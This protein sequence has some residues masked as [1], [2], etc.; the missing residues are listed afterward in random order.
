MQSTT[1]HSTTFVAPRFE[2][3]KTLFLQVKRFPQAI[4]EALLMDRSVLQVQQILAGEAIFW[5]AFDPKTGKT[6]YTDSETELRIWIAQNYR[7]E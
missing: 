6:V 1:H 5:Y 4:V 3:L 7:E 2:S